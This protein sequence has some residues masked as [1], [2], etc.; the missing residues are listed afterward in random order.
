[1]IW[2]YIIAAL[3]LTATAYAE[4]E[5]CSG[6]LA[7][8]YLSFL[9]QYEKPHSFLK[10]EA[11]PRISYE[12]NYKLREPTRLSMVYLVVEQGDDLAAIAEAL[13][14]QDKPR[15]IETHLRLALKHSKIA[16]LPLTE[17]LKIPALYKTGTFASERGPNCFNAVECWNMGL[18]LWRYLD[19]SMFVQFLQAHGRMLMPG[20]DLRF[21]DTLVVIPKGALDLPLHAAIYINDKFVW[22]KAGGSKETPWNFEETAIALAPYG[23]GAPVDHKYLDYLAVFRMKSTE[24]PVVKTLK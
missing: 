9:S 16:R 21:G 3:L 17:V 4:E 11:G 14:V 20:E 8:R 5:D 15:R 12:V 10:F 18:N 1:M 24:K 22:E 6:K 7:P 19:P 2:K 13:A 23:L